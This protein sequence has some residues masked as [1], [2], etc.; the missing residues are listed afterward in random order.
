MRLCF[1]FLD[2]N[3]YSLLKKKQQ[4][5]SKSIMIEDDAAVQCG[6]QSCWTMYYNVR[7]KTRACAASS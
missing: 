3:A 1:S 2:W 5:N 4:S 6:Q 7:D